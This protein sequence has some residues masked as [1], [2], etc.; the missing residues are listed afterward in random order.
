MNG[1]SR[2]GSRSMQDLFGDLPGSP[3]EGLA[4][5]PR[6]LLRARGERPADTACRSG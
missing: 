4:P 5:D 2:R 1:G 6:L 3:G